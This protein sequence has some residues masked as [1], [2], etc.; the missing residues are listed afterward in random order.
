MPGSPSVS[1]SSF[2]GS[3]PGFF[4]AQFIGQGSEQNKRKALLETLQSKTERLEP[5][6]LVV[7]ISGGLDS[8]TL[9]HLLRHTTQPRKNP[10]YP[11]YIY[12]GIRKEHPEAA[13]LPRYC[14]TLG[15]TLRC[16]RIQ[17][18]WL[19]QQAAQRGMSLEDLARTHRY[20]R[21]EHYFLHLSAQLAASAGRGCLVLA[22]HAD[23]QAEN[24][25]MGLGRGAGLAAIAGMREWQMR[26]PSCPKLRP[27]LRPSPT[28]KSQQKATQIAQIEKQAGR[29][30]SL[31]I[32]PKTEH[33]KIW[34]PLL[35]WEQKDLQ[36]WAKIHQLPHWED[37][38]NFD[39]NAMRSFY[40]WQV[41]PQLKRA[42][43]GFVQGLRRTQRQ[44]IVHEDAIEQ[45]RSA[46]R[47]GL[48]FSL[49]RGKVPNAQNA[50]G[51]TTSVCWNGALHRL[52]C[53]AQ[54]ELLFLLFDELHRDCH[55]AQNRLPRRFCTELLRQ[56]QNHR[57]K[58]RKRCFE[59]RAHGCLWR[60]EAGRVCA[61]LRANQKG[62]E[63]Q[64]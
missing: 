57:S 3:F 26:R 29:Q 11:C 45:Q 1:L 59:M 10:L 6:P 46:L 30:T 37:L 54:I 8:V 17:G 42:V 2:P 15:L 63:R 4:P 40:R 47:A 7:A 21:L 60:L 18:G 41:L 35:D 58:G 28:K 20:Q 44:L 25:L 5:G 31:K 38:S 27:Q 52:P 49:N 61:S 33:M 22:H 14:R 16:F 51:Q 62:T 55:L 23:D 12:H 13:A 9:L 48:V 43:P 56:W 53:P 50:Q 32:E 39:Q 24:L 36:R 19:A 64:K 34:R